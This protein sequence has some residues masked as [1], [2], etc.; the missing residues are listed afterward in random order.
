[1][2]G[3]HPVLCEG[4]QCRVQEGSLVSKDVDEIHNGLSFKCLKLVVEIGLAGPRLG[5][6]NCNGMP[7]IHADWESSSLLN[8]SQFYPG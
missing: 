5:P 1:M 3:L 8:L 4:G 6:G 2:E 7:K